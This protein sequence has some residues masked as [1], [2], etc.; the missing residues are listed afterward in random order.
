MSTALITFISL[1]SCIFSKFLIPV[2][3]IFDY[4]LIRLPSGLPNLE[5]IVKQSYN[6]SLFMFV[7]GVA[8]LAEHKVVAL[9]VAGSSPVTLPVNLKMGDRMFFYR[10]A[11]TVMVL[12][13]LLI[14]GC[15]VGVQNK[16]GKEPAKLEPY[17]ERI[18]NYVFAVPSN[19]QRKDDLSMI[20][21]NKGTVRAYL[22]YVGKASTPRLVSFFE[23][24][25]KKNGWKKELF[26]AGEDTVLAFSRDGQ[27]IVFKIQQEFNS[28]LL[29]VLLTTQ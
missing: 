17:T 14:S 15:T 7:E 20:Y 19:F 2:N 3:H 16:L 25:M 5:K 9:G 4:I 26:I 27:L 24:Y 28:T 21:E 12:A 11:L 29:K 10:I 13:A 6:I 8:Q 22:V 23:K 18:G 1:F